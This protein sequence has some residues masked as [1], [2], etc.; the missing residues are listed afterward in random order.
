ML[1]SGKYDL[2]HKFFWKMKRSGLAPKALTYKVLVRTFWKEGKVDEAVVAVKDME[3][4]GVVGTAAV[5]YELACCLC[6]NGRWQEAM[7]LVEKLKTLRLTKPLEVAF[8]GMIKSCMNGGHVYDCISIFESMNDHCTPNTGTMNAMLK[9]YGRNDLF[10]K[11]KELFEETKEKDLVYKDHYDTGTGTS[12]TPDVYSY[13]L[14]LEASASAEQWEYFDYVYK[15]MVLSGFQLDQI[16]H[17]WLLVE[18][19][20]AGKVNHYSSCLFLR[21][22][23]LVA[24]C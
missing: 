22:S 21:Y 23:Y 3:E 19:S 10:S 20:R 17:G 18:A 16:K 9:V 8:T 12:L 15:E 2:V 1:E 5:Y 14:M 6:Y 11:A 24:A 13:I 7:M 4:R